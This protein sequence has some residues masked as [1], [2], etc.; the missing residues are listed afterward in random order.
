MVEAIIYI[1]CM[2]KLVGYKKASDTIHRYQWTLQ[3]IYHTNSYNLCYTSLKLQNFK[4]VRAWMLDQ[5][6][7][8]IFE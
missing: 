6:H 1:K 4:H 8:S 7:Q 5:G 3:R 2:W